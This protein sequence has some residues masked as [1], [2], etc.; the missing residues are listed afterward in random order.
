[1][2]RLHQ[3]YDAGRTAL[4]EARIARLLESLAAEGMGA[5]ERH[6]L[7]EEVLCLRAAGQQRR[8]RAKVLALRERTEWEAG[9]RAADAADPPIVVKQRTKKQTRQDIKRFEREQRKRQTD[10]EEARKRRLRKYLHK[11]STPHRGSCPCVAG[12]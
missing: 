10:R 1:V 8:L 3:E 2:P 7:Q 12:E 9:E 5:E 4:E 6:A 11:V